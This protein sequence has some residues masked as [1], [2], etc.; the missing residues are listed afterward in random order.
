MITVEEA[1][2][3]VLQNL[4]RPKPVMVS[5]NE[6]CGRVLAE[7]V[8]ADRDFPPFDR[9]A[10]DGIAIRWEDWS[11]GTR[12]FVIEAVQAAG[13]PAIS[14]NNKNGCIEVMTG[15]VLPTGTD[16][17]IRYEDLA[18]T[19]GVATVI[20]TEIKEKQNVHRQGNDVH[21]D[22]IILNTGMKLSSAEIALLA[23]VR[24]SEVLVQSLPSVAVVSTGDELVEIDRMPEPHQIRRSN[25]YAIESSLKQK[26]CVVKQYHLTDDEE[27]LGFSLEKIISDYDA[28]VLSGGVSKGKFDFLPKVLKEIGIEERF[29]QV[30][31]RPGKPFWFGTRGDGKTVFALPGN[32]VSTFMCLHRYVIAWLHASLELPPPMSKAILATDFEFIP[33]LTY[34]LQVAVRNDDGR[35]LAHPMAG[36]GSGDFANLK[37]VDGFLELPLEKSTFK[38]GEVYSFIPF[39]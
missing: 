10:M 35:F 15:S 26:G 1:T 8:R 17:V 7:P 27:I 21:A 29:H 37:E 16:T 34:F 25:S 24:K 32:P 22:E 6:A 13:M 14:L 19:K 31:Q 23:S 18:I 3:I 30:S 11:Q 5:I 4:Y 2:R 28:I 9:V 39:R 12:D 36:G 20:D 38:A 33:R